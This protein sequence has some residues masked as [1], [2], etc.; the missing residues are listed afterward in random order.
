MSGA[1]AARQNMLATETKKEAPETS[2]A[3][4]KY[5][6]IKISVFPYFFVVVKKCMTMTMT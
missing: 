5:S 6:I 3:P 1:F 2:A 4:E